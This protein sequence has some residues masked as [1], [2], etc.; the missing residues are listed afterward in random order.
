MRF[1]LSLKGITMDTRGLKQVL[2]KSM[3]ANLMQL[4]P[5]QKETKSMFV[6]VLSEY[7]GQNI[8]ETLCRTPEFQRS[9]AVAIYISTDQ[10]VDTM[11]MITEILSK[12]FWLFPFLSLE[13][14]KRCYIPKITKAT[15]TMTFY[16]I[17]S[18][19]EIRAFPVNNYGIREPVDC[20]SRYFE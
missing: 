5:L 12:L 17:H 3:K 13:Q 19:D 2:R 15:D 7:A 11:P 10:E 18:P 14:Q 20:E 8:K 4:S 6:H 1:W 9:K 16:R